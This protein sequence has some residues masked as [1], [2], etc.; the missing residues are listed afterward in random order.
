MI[1]ITKNAGVEDTSLRQRVAGFYL[2]SH[3]E[4]HRDAFTDKAYHGEN[5]DQW[6][7]SL[8]AIR[9]FSYLPEYRP[10]PYELDPTLLDRALSVAKSG[11]RLSDPVIE[12]LKQAPYVEVPVFGGNPFSETRIIVPQQAARNR[13]SG[14]T[15]NRSGYIV[16]GE[17]INT[18]KELYVLKLD[19]D[20]SAFLDG[21]LGG[22]AIYKIGLSMSPAT[23]R[24]SFNKS[25]PGDA[26]EWKIHRT[27]RL[28]GHAAYPTFEA[29]LAGE[30]AMKDVLGAHGEWMGGEFY[31]ATPA[32]VEQA[33]REAAFAYMNEI[34]AVD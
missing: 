1:Y 30:E 28:D 32:L 33:W 17:P 18:E 11:E 4:G 13:V 24:A 5:A 16:D 27:T 6:Q 34:A 21:G 29:A 8:K 14:G 26:L 3:E 22:F 2:V 19:G 20:V 10:N 9:A 7:H 12:A 15:V 31:A 25:L 23:R